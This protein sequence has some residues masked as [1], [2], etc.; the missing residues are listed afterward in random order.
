MD[1]EIAAIRKRRAALGMMQAELAKEAGV[2]Q[3]LVAKLE[4]GRSDASYSRVRRILDALEAKEHATGL[5]ARDAMSRR[6]RAI[7]PHE[8]A[9]GAV[10]LMRKLGVS[11]LP[12]VEGESVVGSISEEAVL[13]LVERGANLAQETIATVM[14]PPFPQID[15]GAPLQAATA[16]LMHEKAVLITRR[17]KIAGI[18]TK[19]DVLS[20]AS[21]RHV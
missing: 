4:A 16:L 3:S 2:S 15:E 11:Q 12:V 20:A 19:S 21:K 17:G 7:P 6:V 13:A 8:K 5:K 9:S 1:A 10:A 14:E 18:I